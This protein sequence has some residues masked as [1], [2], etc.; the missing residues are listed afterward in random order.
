MPITIKDTI[1]TAGLRTTAGFPPLRDHVPPAN[2]PTVQRLVDAGAIVFGKTNTPLLAADWQ[3]F[4]PIFGPTN[5]P[6][7]PTRTPG[8]SSGGSAAAIA[9]GLSALE[10]GSDIG[11]SIR[12][13]AHWTGVYGHKPTHGIVPGRGH[14]PPMP[15]GLS[16]ADLAVLGPIARSAADLDLAL[17]LLA[18]PLPDHATAWRLALPPPRH[19]LLR[20]F[21]V[22][23]WIDDDEYPVDPEVRRVLDDAIAALRAAGV[24]VD[25]TARPA[26]TLADALRVYQ[27]LLWPILTS[28]AP[29]E[30]FEALVRRAAESGDA[31]TRDFEVLMARGAALRHRDW[32][33]VH[34]AR[35]HLRAKLAEFFRDW[36]VLLMPVNQVTAIPHDESEPMAMRRL[37]VGGAERQYLEL[38]AWIC[39][40]TVTLAPATAAPIGRTPTNL[41]VGLQIVGPYLEDTTTIAFARALEDVTGRFVPPPGF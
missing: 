19:Q 38:F 33:A 27:P 22:A 10:L 13:P 12:V 36:D 14:V 40:A 7:D 3:S 35:E 23:V 32:L 2:A 16:E 8:G 6:W 4:N 30:V 37:L 25:D 34:E 17:G 9:A 28:G 26:F 21:R 20:D 5:N 39:L 1:E 24:R 11:G 18:G 41:P 31:E 29:P 15:G